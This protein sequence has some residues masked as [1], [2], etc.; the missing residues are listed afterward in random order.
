MLKQKKSRNI[1]NLKYK[2]FK[3]YI[4]LYS[5]EV[6][7]KMKTVPTLIIYSIIQ[8]QKERKMYYFHQLF[9]TQDSILIRSWLR[10][11]LANRF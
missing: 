8:N 2:D 9:I 1:Y 5:K 11:N 10:K 6:V 7:S 3:K 4:K